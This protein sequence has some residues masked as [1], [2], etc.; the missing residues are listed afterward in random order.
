MALILYQCPTVH[1]CTSVLYKKGRGESIKDF[2]T[3]KKSLISDVLF[4][5][6][7]FVLHSL[8]P[9]VQESESRHFLVYIETRE[10]WISLQLLPNVC[11]TGRELVHSTVCFIVSAPAKQISSASLHLKKEQ[12]SSTRS[13]CN[14]SGYCEDFRQQDNFQVSRKGPLLLTFLCCF[15][16]C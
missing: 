2:F 9:P 1:L 11:S 13:Q 8:H 4:L 7:D 14:T 12:R 15:P 3:K 6:L 16:K 10:P 5:R